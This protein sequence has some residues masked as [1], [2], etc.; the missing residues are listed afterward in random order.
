ME[1][2]IHKVIILVFD[3]WRMGYICF[4]AQDPAHINKIKNLFQCW[5]KHFRG[6]GLSKR[7]VIYKQ[8]PKRFHWWLLR[9]RL[10]GSD[11][12]RGSVWPQNRPR[13]LRFPLEFWIPMEG[14]L[15]GKVCLAPQVK[16][17]G[18]T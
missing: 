13:P 2:G 17:M 9:S 11:N 4:F 1:M 18:S 5:T 14:L 12:R 7:K 8:L 15:L 6:T 10:P 3:M 16:F